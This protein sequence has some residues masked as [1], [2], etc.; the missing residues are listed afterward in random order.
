MNR[1]EILILH[2]LNENDQREWLIQ[3]GLL[4]PTMTHNRENSQEGYNVAYESIADCAYRLCDRAVDTVKGKMA[5]GCWARK[6]FPGSLIRWMSRSK[7][8]HIIQASLL[9]LMDEETP[10]PSH[11]CQIFHIQNCHICDDIKCGD[12]LS[13]TTP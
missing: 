4:A 12:N 8:I 10:S 3:N 1:D 2:K 13:R 5:F 7:P 9:A 6:I 11:L